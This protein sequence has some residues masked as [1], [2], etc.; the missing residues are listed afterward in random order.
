[1]QIS[2]R[3]APVLSLLAVLILAPLGT[4]R[5]LPVLDMLENGNE[6]NLFS[7]YNQIAGTSY[8][9]TTAFEA[10]GL[11]IDPGSTG[12]S[13]WNG[14]VWSGDDSSV[15]VAIHVDA[16]HRN[17]FGMYTGL[18]DG[19]GG[20]ILFA[21]Q[22]GHGSLG[23]DEVR[24]FAPGSGGD[25]GFFIDSSG[26]G[27]SARWHSGSDLDSGTDFAH[28]VAYAFGRTISINSLELE[29]AVLLGWE[30]LAS[31]SSADADY[32]DLVLIAGNTT[33]VQPVPEPGT[34]LLLG[35]GLSALALRRRA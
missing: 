21:D 20:D 7:L 16:G 33:T 26:G 17:S 28:V 19:S 30:D 23:L 34:A 25:V 4:A 12:H 13:S 8:G 24:L 1:M 32:N 22:S 14:E 35:L 11:R 10:A 29:N 15:V 5:A 27:A 3:L 6:T 31:R 2:R 18:T 9:S